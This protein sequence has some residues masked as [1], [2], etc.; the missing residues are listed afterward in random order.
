M[1]LPAIFEYRVTQMRTAARDDERVLWEVARADQVVANLCEVAC[2][3]WEEHLVHVPD[4]M[5]ECFP[6]VDL[7][8]FGGY[9]KFSQSLVRN[10]FP[11]IQN[12]EWIRAVTEPELSKGRYLPCN[13]RNGDVDHAAL[14]SYGI[15][16]FL[17]ER[18]VFL[19]RV[20]DDE[21]MTLGEVCATLR[22]YPK[23]AQSAPPTVFTRIR[24]CG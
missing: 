20:R 16:A 3:T 23:T 22:D 14:P 2:Y 8:L 1:P 10:A 4:A 9:A 24:D 13:W 15:T 17:R 18:G 7:S 5:L 19:S 12:A 21:R 6:Q 11:A